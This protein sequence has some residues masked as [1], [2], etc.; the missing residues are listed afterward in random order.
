MLT[1][2][3][4]RFLF[5]CI[6]LKDGIDEI[7]QPGVVER[8]ENKVGYSDKYGRLEAKLSIMLEAAHTIKGT[9]KTS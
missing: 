8:L 6:K 9:K 5:K 4:I 7:L 2:E 1:I 3:D